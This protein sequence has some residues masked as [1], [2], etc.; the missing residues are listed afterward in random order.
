M[1]S[2]RYSKFNSIK[3]DVIENYLVDRIKSI[4]G[5]C[6]KFDPRNSRGLH[7]RICFIPG[8]LL[9]LVEVKRPGAKPR[10]NQVAQIAAFRKMGFQSTWVDTKIKVDKLVAWIRDYQKKYKVRPLDKV[11]ERSDCPMRRT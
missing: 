3:E 8:G 9:L 2:H 10:K 7:D 5:R 11:C 1:G 4:G 6:I